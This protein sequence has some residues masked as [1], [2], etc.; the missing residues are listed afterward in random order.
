MSLLC[1]PDVN[2]R[3]AQHED[4]HTYLCKMNTQNHLLNGFVCLILVLSFPSC[5]LQ[6]SS[7]VS[8]EELRLFVLTETKFAV[9]W[10]SGGW[11]EE[12]N[13][14]RPVCV[15]HYLTD[16]TVI[17]SKKKLSLAPDCNNNDHACDSTI[18]FAAS[19]NMSSWYHGAYGT[20]HR[21]TLRKLRP[22]SVYSLHVGYLAA[23]GEDGS[24]DLDRTLP[25]ET[26]TFRTPIARNS[27]SDSPFRFLLLAD[28]STTSSSVAVVNKIAQEVICNTV[29][30]RVIDRYLLFR[31]Q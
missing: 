28:T 19:S 22:S 8:I 16:D 21:C 17:S 2:D 14:V 27:F 15:Y 13:S 30:S 31:R 1:Q 5:A 26:T 7:E 11:S 24:V 9:I 20:V 6:E 25:W 18:A 23:G 29:F 4:E 3:Y 12:L 10:K